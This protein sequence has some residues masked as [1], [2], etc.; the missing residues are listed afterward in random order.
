MSS[1]SFLPPLP[2]SAPLKCAIPAAALVR[3]R[4]LAPPSTAST[5]SPFA[6]E[7][8]AKQHGITVPL[9]SDYSHSVVKAYDVELPDLIGL[10]PAA[11]RAAVVVGSDGIVKYSEQTAAI[12]GLPDFEKTK[13]VLAGA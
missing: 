13:S 2:A 10:G 1:S 11:A 5:D 12:T 6:Q 4:A 3:P 9:L 8:W 7:A